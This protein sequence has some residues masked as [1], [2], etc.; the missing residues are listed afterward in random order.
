VFSKLNAYFC[1][2]I[3]R[4]WLMNYE[5]LLA[6]R[7]GAALKKD[8]MPFG[9]FY[10]KIGE[11]TYTNI[12]ELRYEL[13]DSLR[14]CEALKA[15]SE[16]VKAFSDRHQL[17]YQVMVDSAGFCSVAVENGYFMTFEHLINDKPSVVAEKEFVEQVMDALFESAATLNRQGVYHLCFSPNNMLVRKDTLAPLLLFHGSSYLTLNDQES[18]YG[19][20]AEYVAPEV[21]E[22]GV[23]DARSEVYSLG[24]FLAYLY[25]DSSVPVEYRAVIKKATQ[26][27]PDK[28]Y[29]SVADMKKTMKSFHK[30]RHSLTIGIAAVVLAVIAIGLY[31]DLTPNPE[32]IEYVEAAP[33]ENFD[34]EDSPGPYDPSME[35]DAATDST[36]YHIDE[37]EMQIY[38]KK[39][40]EIFRKR[41]TEEADRILSKI[42]NA[43]YM[44]SSE[45]KFLAESTEIMTELTQKQAELGSEAGLTD[46]KSQR[47]ASE[48]IDKISN[49]KK[50]Q[51]EQLGVQKQ[52]NKN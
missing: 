22:E 34:D 48:I 23:A 40:E 15:E 17:H 13:A 38:E 9:S 36:G 10:R 45:K 49:E 29:E 32:N 31:I 33:K 11:N 41:F 35:L 43:D 14:F 24:K 6:S 47:I 20:D 25:R 21:L 42:Y 8:P 5:E 18:L 44:S 52:K 4:F 12:L 51:L 27:N 30:L 28:R 1:P 16:Q 7:N 26:A 3:S 46:A 37:D 50:A 2:S 19:A 39:A